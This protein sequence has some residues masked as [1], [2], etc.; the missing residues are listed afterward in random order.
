MTP[1]NMGMRSGLAQVLG[2]QGAERDAHV[3]ALVD[4]LARRSAIAQIAPRIGNEGALS[5]ALA[6]KASYDNLRKKPPEIS[7]P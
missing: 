3:S 2:A 7:Q 6:A 5:L 4:A 1:D